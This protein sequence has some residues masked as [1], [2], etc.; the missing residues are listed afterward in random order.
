MG[1][2][3]LH[4]ESPQNLVAYLSNSHFVIVSYGSG[5]RVGLVRQILLGFCHAVEAVS[6][7]WLCEACPI[8]WLEAIDGGYRPGPQ[9]A[10]SPHMGSPRGLLSS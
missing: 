5:V 4:N 9:L 3:L 1:Y 7:W 6:D 2:Q 10:K 8:T